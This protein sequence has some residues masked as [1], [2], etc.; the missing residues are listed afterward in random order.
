ML[1]IDL[2]VGDFLKG[3][4]FAWGFFMG[5][6]RVVLFRVGVIL[7]EPSE[8]KTGFWVGYEFLIILTEDELRRFGDGFI[9]VDV[10]WLGH[11]LEW[12]DVNHLFYE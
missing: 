1:S 4:P 5:Y 10:F 3:I 9:V 12:I 7:E 6:G 11:F 2:K 8:I